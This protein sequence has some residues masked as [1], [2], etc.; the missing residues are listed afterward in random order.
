MNSL[1]TNIEFFTYSNE[2]MVR[3]A[4][5]SVRTLS[6]SDYSLVD[7]V[8]DYLSTF[9]PKAYAALCEEYK[10]SAL[11]QHYFRFR[12]V[13]RFVRCNFGALDNVNDISTTL[14]CNF[15]YVPCPLRGEC[16]LDRIVCNPEF[17]HQLSPAEFQVLRLVYDGIS[18]EVIAERLRLSPHT[19]HSHVRNAYARLNIHS[20]AEF[21]R[22]ASDNSI[23]S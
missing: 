16:H 12:I 10:Q 20:K 7:E 23:F 2:V 15:E 8:C 3:T 22:Y 11:N 18:E 19:I 1:L 13:S 9:Y 4:D 5:G 17:N 6:P 14:H 21:I